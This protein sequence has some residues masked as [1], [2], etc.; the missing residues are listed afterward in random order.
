MLLVIFGLCSQ[1]FWMTSSTKCPCLEDESVVRV[2]GFM[3]IMAADCRLFFSVWKVSDVT[4]KDYCAVVKWVS[5]V[6][7]MRV[8]C[9]FWCDGAPRTA[10]SLPDDCMALSCPYSQGL[11][12]GRYKVLDTFFTILLVHFSLTAA[13]DSQAWLQFASLT[14]WFAAYFHRKHLF[15]YAWH[16]YQ[17]LAW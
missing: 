14:S 15:I 13:F 8:N 11:L 7:G 4:N 6:G 1:T 5:C 12:G 9:P 3:H 2:V 10:C 17:V 16:T